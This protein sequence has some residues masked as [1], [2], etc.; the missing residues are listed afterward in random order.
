VLRL[1]LE[2]DVA[3]LAATARLLDE[4]AFGLERLLEVSR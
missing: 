4:L 2:P 3:V 1:E